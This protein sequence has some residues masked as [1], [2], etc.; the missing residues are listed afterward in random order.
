MQAKKLGISTLKVGTLANG[1]RR[2]WIHNANKLPSSF[3][4]GD[5]LQIHFDKENR[6]IT[7]DKSAALTGHKVSE[8]KSSNTPLIDLKNSEVSETMKDAKTVEVAFYHNRIVITVSKEEIASNNRK[9]KVNLKT[10]ELFCGGGILSNQF[11]IAGFEVAGGLEVEHKYLKMFEKNHGKDT[12]T[13]LGAIEDIHL[14]DL[15]KDIGVLLAGIPCDTFSP[16]NIALTK[17]IQAKEKGEEHNSAMT[18]TRLNAEAMV[19]YVMAAIREMRVHTVVIEEVEK[20]SKTIAAEFLKNFCRSLGYHVTETVTTGLHSKRKRWTM[21]AS[22]FKPINLENIK[23]ESDIQIKDLLEISVEDRDWKHIDDMPRLKNAKRK[24][25]V[26]VRYCLPEDTK[27][28][29]FTTHNTRSTEPA[30]RR[31]MDS[32]YYDEFSNE[33]IKKIHGVEDY[34]LPREKT[35]ARQIL[36]QGVTDQWIEIATLIKDSIPAPSNNV[37][38]QIVKQ[39]ENDENFSGQKLFSFVS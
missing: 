22:S 36:G 32:E 31:D 33:E 12:Y 5:P 26:G 29:T 35:V 39:A 38:T 28:N 14:S 19:Y 25:T 11:K 16:G 34:Q 27:C 6:A 8:R 3:N 10:F 4:I 18:D 21:V 24:S 2:I 7:I 1:N 37:T 30:L 17:E 23:Q 20:F 13:I 15:P 9:S